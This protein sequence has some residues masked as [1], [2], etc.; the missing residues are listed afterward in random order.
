LKMTVNSLPNDQ[1]CETK[2]HGLVEPPMRRRNGV[3]PVARRAKVRKGRDV[4]DTA[5]WVER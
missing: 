3:G 4:V 2:T 5:D 1:S